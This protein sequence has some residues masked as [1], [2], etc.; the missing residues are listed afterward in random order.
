LS[1]PY[2]PRRIVG[3]SI[4]TGYSNVKSLL[5]DSVSAISSLQWLWYT[6]ESINPD[7][8]PILPA[9]E[10]LTLTFRALDS[11][12]FRGDCEEGIGNM[13]RNRKKHGFPI[14][15][16]TFYEHGPLGKENRFMTFE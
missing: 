14:R 1:V 7:R 12:R 6:G 9:L 4:F 2:L 16:C 13:G 11:A 15:E 5:I 10:S 3:K 8:M